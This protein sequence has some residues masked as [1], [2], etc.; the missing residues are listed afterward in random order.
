MNLTSSVTAQDSKQQFLQLLVAQVQHQD[1]LEPIQQ[2]DFISQLAQ[3][4][5]LEGIE[6]LNAQFS[7]M[8]ELQQLTDGAQL[9]GRD[10]RFQLDGESFIG[11]VDE[12]TMS[13]GRLSVGIGGQ[14]LP[15]SSID[16]IVDPA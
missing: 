11:H 6:T 16:A 4:S 1:P 5:T 7:D 12:V 10:V 2:E 15:L 3:F 8:L 14:Y 9:V 13:D